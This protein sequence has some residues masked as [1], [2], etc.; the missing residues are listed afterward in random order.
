MIRDISKH[1][2][3]FIFLILLQI[4]VLNNIEFS[5]Y[6]NPYLYILFIILLPFETPNWMLLVSAF[7]LGLCV[8][9]FSHT[10][11]MHTFSTVLI[12]FLRPFI[13]K[14]IAP[15][16]GYEAGSRP[17]A[18]FLGFEWFMKYAIILVV[19]HHFSLFYIEVFKFHQ[20][21]ATLL[22]VILSSIFTLL[23][24]ALSQFITL[25]R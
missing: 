20:F 1:I 21:F 6:I 22:R 11:G 17:N 9:F 18:N 15:R 7:M 10:L 12:A 13:L 19:V 2:G 8:D 16:E 3:N 14:F 5:G 24:I 4:L 23:L 25:K